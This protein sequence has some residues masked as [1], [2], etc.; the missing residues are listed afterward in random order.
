MNVQEEQSITSIDD[1]V[2]YYRRVNWE[3]HLY[4]G[5]EWERSGVY[6]EDYTPVQYEGEN[7]YNAVLHKLVEEVGWEVIESDEDDLL[8]LQRGETRVTIEGDGRLELAGSPQ[9]ILHDLARELRIHNNEVVE[10]GNIFG[11]GWLPLGLQPLN[12]NADIQMMHK[13]RYRIFQGIGDRELM[14]TMTKRLN[15]LTANLSYTNEENAVRKAQTAFRVLPIVGAMFA[16]SGLE[17]G[18]ELGLLNERRRVIQGHAPDRTGIPS[19]ILD[20]DFSLAD[21]LGY[22]AD[23][24]VVLI[25]R[26][27]KEVRTDEQFTFRQWMEEGREGRHPTARDFD[28][29]VKTTW[30]DIRLR[31]SYL[32]YRVPDSVPF[33]F[34]MALPA[35]MKGLIFDSENWE[36]VAQLT[37]GWTYQD[38]LDLDRRAWKDGLQ[39]EVDGKPLLLFAQELL[40]LANQKLHSFERLD[41]SEQDE[42]VYLTALKEQI[43]IKEKSPAEEIRDCFQGEWNE[44][45]TRVLAWCEGE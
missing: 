13:E 39:T 37:Q 19:S 44:E 30:S 27:G 14:E 40:M 9:E 42:T 1:L 18:K 24:P 34:V 25:E 41:G 4:V 8:E 20:A 22:Y 23:L 15:G 2:T 33:R 26:D 38:V 10:M 29:H 35:L 11:I 5:I 43:F 12:N 17:N 16:S 31:P 28:R 36:A 32:E 45:A 21:W 3:K 7:G 6:R